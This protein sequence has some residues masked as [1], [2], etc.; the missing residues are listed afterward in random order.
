M[1]EKNTPAAR[2]FYKAVR[3][4]SLR[5]KGWETAVFY[6]V[7]PDEKFDLT[8]VSERVYGNRYEFLTVMAAAGLDR[9]DMPLS[10]T[11]LILPTQNQLNRI[12]RATG[13]ESNPDLRK[14]FKPTWDKNA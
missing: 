11:Q 6:E 2:N 9:F 7:K 5:T 13:F 12:K 3:E 1:I 8:L 10:Q 14:N 4:F